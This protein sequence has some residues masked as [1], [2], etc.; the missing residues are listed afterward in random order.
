MRGRTVP[1]ESGVGNQ[2]GRA[3]GEPS[4][5]HAATASLR[6][7]RRVVATRVPVECGGMNR[8]RIPEWLER[9]AVERDRSCVYCGVSFATVNAS[10]RGMP[11]WE[12]II[13]DASIAT[14]GNIVRC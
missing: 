5:R 13:N 8:W 12:H 2:Q 4:R 10:R 11:S 7:A 1:G 9:K 3:P 14:T 6:Q